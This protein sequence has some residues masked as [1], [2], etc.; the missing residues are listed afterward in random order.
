M[1]INVMQK[2]IARLRTLL[3]YR[4]LFFLFLSRDIKLKYRRS[5]LGYLWSIL[6]PF[7]N[8]I[9]LSIVFS[10]LFARGI[11]N[12]PIYVLIGSILF[13]FM[14][15]STSRSLFS[16]IQNTGLL[17]KIYVPKYIFTLATVTSE[18]I[19]FLF[20]LGALV[21]MIVVTKAPVSWRFFFVFIPIAEVYIF[22]IGMGLFLAQAS[23]FFRDI[24]H[25]WVVII[26]A[27]NFLSAIFYPADILPDYLYRIVSRYNP[28]FFYITMF[29]NF[30]IGG[31]N[32]SNL[33]MALRGAV[34]AGL[35]LLVGLVSF[36]Y[37][38][39]KFILYI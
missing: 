8:M 2:T 1:P 14:S 36:S 33:D 6:N 13:T 19:I 18:L 5:F 39:N 16:V 24:R 30:T 37:S 12:F 31:S 7:L 22:C 15:E 26:T 23:V 21:I 25:I 35:M 10:N 17:K 38:K 4:E 29:R 34:A 20:S 32:I 9:V 11:P 3:K 27:W 28:M